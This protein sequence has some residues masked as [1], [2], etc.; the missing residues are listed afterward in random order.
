MGD[1]EQIDALPSETPGAKEMQLSWD[2]FQALL[3]LKQTEKDNG[4]VWAIAATR[5]EELHAWIAYAFGAVND[6][7]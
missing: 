3:R 5:A 2:L 7:E 6:P 4:R 1:D